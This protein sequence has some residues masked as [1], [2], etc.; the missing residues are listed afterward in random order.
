[1]TLTSK[2]VIEND[3]ITPVSEASPIV[4]GSD[5]PP[6]ALLRPFLSVT[7]DTKIAG[8][9]LGVTPLQMALR[10]YRQV[11]WASIM[12]C[13]FDHS[14]IGRRNTLYGGIVKFAGLGNLEILRCCLIMVCLLKDPPLD[15]VR[16]IVAAQR[17]MVP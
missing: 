7:V 17:L 12:H 10:A 2:T 3:G 13:K 15:V 11:E 16:L 5:C 4:F 9:C 14:N 6:V 1:M 8:R